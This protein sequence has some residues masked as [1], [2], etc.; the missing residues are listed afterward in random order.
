MILKPSTV[1]KYRIFTAEIVAARKKF[2]SESV[3]YSL[4][5]RMSH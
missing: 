5:F 4:Y 3:R 2:V 1:L